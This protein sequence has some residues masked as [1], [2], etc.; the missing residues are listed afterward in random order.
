M[1]EVFE[2]NTQKYKLY[3][4]KVEGN[5][6]HLTRQRISALSPYVLGSA[7]SSDSD[8]SKLKLIMIKGAFG[9]PTLR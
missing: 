5:F 3:F 2:Q 6:S 4:E 1:A 8:R 9:N 7:I